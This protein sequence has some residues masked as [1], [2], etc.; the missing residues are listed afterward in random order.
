MSLSSIYCITTHQ[1][2][3]L[4]QRLNY[5]IEHPS[6]TNQCWVSRALT[7]LL[8]QG[9]CKKVHTTHTEVCNH[10]GRRIW[11]LRNIQQWLGEACIP[12]LATAQGIGLCF[13]LMLI[14]VFWL[15][16]RTKQIRMAAYFMLLKNLVCTYCLK[17]TLYFYIHGKSKF[18]SFFRV[19]LCSSQIRLCTLLISIN[20]WTM[21]RWEKPIKIQTGIYKC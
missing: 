9:A 2:L 6:I 11:Q 14:Q 17:E 8:N 5:L 20:I 10:F 19:Q 18:P 21:F 1:N 16:E 15:E 7:T 12:I 3:G 13:C 4:E